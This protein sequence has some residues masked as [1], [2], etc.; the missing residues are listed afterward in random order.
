MLHAREKQ[1]R[2]WAALSVHQQHAC[3]TLSYLHVS[4]HTQGVMLR[5][6]GSPWSSRR[7]PCTLVERLVA[8]RVVAQPDKVSWGRLTADGLRVGLV[9]WWAGL[10]S[11]GIGACK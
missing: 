3:I 1:T 10:F 9:G 6:P 2:R 4:W 11:S 8:V 7:R 5:T